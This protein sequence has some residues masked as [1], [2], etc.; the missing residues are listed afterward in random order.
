SEPLLRNLHPTHPANYGFAERIPLPDVLKSVGIEL[1]LREIEEPSVKPCSVVIP[2]FGEQDVLDAC[3][4]SL[5]DCGELVKEIVV[6]DDASPKKIKVPKGVKLIR[7]KE[8]LGFAR[9]CNAGFE[10]T[11]G[12]TVLF[13]NSDTIVPRIALTRLLESLW[14]SG[15]IMA[16]GPYSNNVGHF[17]RI[18]PTYT[19]VSR[20]DL[21]AEDFSQREEEDRD[22]DMLVG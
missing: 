14:K 2:A 15:S 9:T 7:N 16:A 1:T 5:A 21:F 12:D 3:L 4:K 22:V 20:L 11:A 6:V 19:D 10:T 8:N 17:Q 18:D 13:L